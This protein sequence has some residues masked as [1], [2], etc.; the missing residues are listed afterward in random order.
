MS[1]PFWHVLITLAA[2]PYA[3]HI[4]NDQMLKCHKYASDAENCFLH[5]TGRVRRFHQH[6]LLPGILLSGMRAVT[7]RG[8]GWRNG[9]DAAD[10][11]LEPRSEVVTYGKDP[12]SVGH[13]TES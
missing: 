6:W 3:G 5:G 8:C 1:L 2:F 13:R 4:L 12:P 11:T 9:P 7:H 10:A